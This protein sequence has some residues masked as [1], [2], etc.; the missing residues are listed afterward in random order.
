MGID[1]TSPSQR[2]E[3]RLN[4]LT[5]ENIENMDVN[6]LFEIIQ[7]IQ[8]LAFHQFKQLDMQAS[9][10]FIDLLH[11]KIKD[12]TKS[13]KPTTTQKVMIVAEFLGGI[14]SCVSGMIP[15]IFA[16][17]GAKAETYKS[18]ATGA[19][20]VAGGAHNVSG[21]VTPMQSGKQS[22]CSQEVQE[23]Q[24]LLSDREHARQKE[25]QSQSEM[26]QGIQRSEQQRSEAFKSVLQ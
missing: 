11:D 7:E 19:Q 3:L 9:L 10:K 22:E 5:Q 20:T 14:G 26:H 8:M 24:R 1:V 25:Q 4:S 6:R 23:T 17:T 12:S 2:L 13:Y 16:L 18:L 21:L 15:G